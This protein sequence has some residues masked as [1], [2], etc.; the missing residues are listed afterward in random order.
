VT[1]DLPD[2]LYARF[3]RL[4]K[5]FEDTPVTLFTRM[6][7]VYERHV[8]QREPEVASALAPAPATNVRTFDPESPPSLTYTMVLSAKLGGVPV[9]SSWNGLLVELIKRAKGPLANGNKNRL[10]IVNFVEGRKEDE[11]YHFIPE[12]GLS[13]QGQDANYA[14][15]GA[16]HLARQLGIPVEVEFLW[17]HKKRA[18]FPGTTG[19]LV[20]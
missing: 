5:P 16:C 11:G 18:K 14:W 15:R 19:R 2:D 10:L 1:F 9:K 3:G 17:R 7:E 6:L 4:A 8:Q 13:V 20:A 12:A